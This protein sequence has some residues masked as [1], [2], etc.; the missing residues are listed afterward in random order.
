M[1]VITSRQDIHRERPQPAFKRRSNNLFRCLTANFDAKRGKG[2]HF[3]PKHPLAS[4][5]VKS[6]TVASCNANP[7]GESM[8]TYRPSHLRGDKSQDR[9]NTAQH[10][11]SPHKKLHNASFK[12]IGVS[13]HAKSRSCGAHV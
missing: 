2:P 9:T 10:V 1:W 12:P 13:Q 3:L 6:T 7:F 8:E 4:G 5:G 11:S